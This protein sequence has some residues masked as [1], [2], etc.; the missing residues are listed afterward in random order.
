MD[1]S[2]VVKY[3]SEL[4][5]EGGGGDGGPPGKRRQLVPGDT[6]PQSQPDS[7]VEEEEKPIEVEIPSPPPHMEQRVRKLG[8]KDKK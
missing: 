6:A 7:P 3:S 8:L 4:A 1:A 5:A 2:G